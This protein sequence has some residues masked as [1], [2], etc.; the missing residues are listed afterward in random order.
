MNRLYSANCAYLHRKC[1]SQEPALEA[2]MNFGTM[3]RKSFALQ[4]RNA[5]F[6]EVKYEKNP[7]LNASTVPLKR[8]FYEL[9][10]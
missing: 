8:V 3:F 9:H 1:L 4:C 10:N 5:N 6:P 7:K 2:L